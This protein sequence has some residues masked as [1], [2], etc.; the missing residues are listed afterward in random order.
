MLK[1]M[2]QGKAFTALLAVALTEAAKLNAKTCSDEMQSLDLAMHIAAGALPQAYA[3][4]QQVG[5]PSDVY[6]PWQTATLHCSSVVALGIVW[7]EIS[8]GKQIS[9]LVV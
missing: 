7:Q 3:L 6:V 2:Q 8:C 5:F 4:A 1:E 9:S